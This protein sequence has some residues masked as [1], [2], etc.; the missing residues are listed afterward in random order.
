M[1]NLA[2]NTK[3]TP[4]KCPT[5]YRSEGLPRTGY[6]IPGRDGTG[7][8]QMYGIVR[9]LT[10][11]LFGGFLRFG[12]LYQGFVYIFEDVVR[13]LCAFAIFVRFWQGFHT[14]AL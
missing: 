5:I 12:K 6:F 3:S 10:R 11:A 8:W 13:M 14:L 4:N 1:L 9:V 2:G 7:A